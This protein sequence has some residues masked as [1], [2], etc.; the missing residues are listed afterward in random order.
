[1]EDGALQGYLKTV[2][3]P[4]VGPD[5]LASAVG[6][7]KYVMKTMLRD[8]GFPVLDCVR[9]MRGGKT[10][11]LTRCVEEN[12]AYPVIVKPVNLGSSVGISKASTQKLEWAH[13]T[14]VPAWRLLPFQTALLALVRVHLVPVLD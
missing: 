6:M 12:L 2:G 1:M 11:E 5:V 3:V 14:V 13:S 8:G 10:D 7:D 9:L 4:F